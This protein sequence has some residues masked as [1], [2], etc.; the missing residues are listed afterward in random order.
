M[1]QIQNRALLFN[2]GV[3]VANNNIRR[4]LSAF[5][6][7]YQTPDGSVDVKVKTLAAGATFTFTPDIPTSV[8]LVETTGTVQASVTLGA[9]T[10]PVRSSMTYLTFI[11]QVLLLDDAVTSVVF[12]NNGTLPIQVTLIQG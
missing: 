1:S 10:S 4:S 3:F 9:L 11:K 2:L 5:T 7:N 12:T 8:L 6:H